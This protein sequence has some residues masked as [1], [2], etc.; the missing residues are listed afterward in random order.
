MAEMTK[1]QLL[2]KLA[3]MEMKN[4]ELEK[5]AAEL[6]AASKPAVEVVNNDPNRRVRIFIDL[7]KRDSE[8]LHVSVND[9]NAVIKRGVEVEVPYFVAKHLEEM[10]AQNNATI[11]MIRGLSAEWAGKSL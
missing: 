9:Y 1:D 6:E 7:D 4:A 3:E 10:K 2:V 8:P 5:K 11:R